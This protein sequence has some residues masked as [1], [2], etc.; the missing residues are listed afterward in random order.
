MSTVF[1]VFSVEGATGEGVTYSVMITRG[2]GNNE[3]RR[4]NALEN[5]KDKF[6]YYSAQSAEIHDGL[7]FDFVNSDL[8]FSPELIKTIKN[9]VD[10]AGGLEYSASF[11]YNFS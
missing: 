6:G 10:H 11:H 9:M 2:Y 3:D 1:T 8:L 7:K 4:R 5:F